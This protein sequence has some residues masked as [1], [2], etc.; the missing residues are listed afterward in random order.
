MGRSLLL[1]GCALA[2]GACGGDEP[3]DPTS[4]TTVTETTGS[5]TDSTAG[6]ETGDDEEI[7]TEP[8]SFS[9]PTGNIGCSM[10]TE[11]V[12]CDIAERE[13]EPGPRPADCPE[14]SDYGQ[15]VVLDTK[16]K[17]QPV[18]AGDT[19]LGAERVL[20]YGSS[21]K[22]GTFSC[23]SSEKGILCLADT[24]NG[25]DYYS[26]GGFRMSREQLSDVSAIE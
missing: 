20:E 17:T 15:G 22:V 13:W 2:L 3:T 9:S 7:S 5:T 11:Q 14:E 1:V 10:T 23:K 12:R 16:G 21:E 26:A 6:S 24:T 18:C 4:T 25:R 19:Q 8:V